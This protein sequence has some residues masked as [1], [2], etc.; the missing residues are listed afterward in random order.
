MTTEDAIGD[1]IIGT[2]K[3]AEIL[4]WSQRR[5]QRA[6]ITDRLPIVGTV[7]SRGE[8]LIRESAVQALAA[9]QAS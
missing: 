5:V 1:P 6:I 9:E 4:H 2:A 3:A 8:Y 7:G